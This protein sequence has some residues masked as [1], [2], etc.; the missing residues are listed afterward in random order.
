VSAPARRRL[1]L[2]RHAQVRYFDGVRP[3]DVVLTER[4]REQA[5][6]AAEALARVAFDRVVTSGLARTLETAR[7]VAPSLEPEAWPELRE[8][9]SGELR[10]LDANAVQEMMTDAFRG[11]VPRESRFLG[12]ETIG[13]LVDRVGA[14]LERLTADDGWDVCLLVLHGGVNRAILSRAATGEPV[15]LGS[16]EQAPG[17]I[18]VLDVA[19]DGSFLVR[20]VNHTPYD[21]AHVRAPRLTTMEHLWQEFLD[22]RSRNP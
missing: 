16:F 8:I 13:S 5:H 22:S 21:P 11:T 10:G 19:R 17:C 4:G 2:M 18:N 3:E 15:F 14:A 1:Y 6:A 12:G 9:E 7:I 20:A